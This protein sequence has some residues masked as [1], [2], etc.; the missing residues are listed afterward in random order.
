MTSTASDANDHGAHG[1]LHGNA[2]K[3]VFIV[4]I[5]FSLFQVWTATFTPLSTQVVRSVHVGFLLLTSFLLFG[6]NKSHGRSQI[7]WYDWV[8]GLT[9]FALGFYHWVFEADLIVR[10]GDPTITDLTVGVIAIA[11][12][13]EAA[14][15]IM[16]LALPLICGVF[17]PY[18]LLGPDLPGP[19]AHRGFGFDQL[20]DQLFLGTEGIYGTPTFVSATY[21]FLFILFGSFLEHA[22]MI[23]LFNDVSLGLVG[24]A[25]GGP[26]KVSVISSGFMGT[27]NGSGVANVLTTGQFTIPLMIKF[28]YRP[29]FAGAV[30][31]TS[32]MGGQIMPPVMGAVAFIM[33]ETIGVPYSEIALAAIIPAVLYYASVFWMVHLEAGRRGLLG[34]PK[35]EC[36]SALKAVRE[37]WYLFLPL[38]ALVTLLFSGYTPLFAGVI[39]LGCTA[40]LIVG[41]ALAGAIPAQLLRWVFWVGLGLSAAALNRAGFRA[42]I[43]IATLVL[44]LALPCLFFAKG[45][46]VLNTI[47]SSMADGARNAVGVGVACA[48][49][50]VLIGVTTLT[51]IASSFAGA[52]VALSGGNLFLA[53]VLTMIA[54]IVLG[55][56]LPTIPNYIITASIA[57]PALLQMG[58]PL[59]VSHMFVFYFGIMADLTPPVA[60]AA[61]AA[62]SIARAGHM[63]IGLLATRIAAAGYVVPFM[64]VYEPALM[65]QGDPSVLLVAYMVFKAL[66][67]IA[68]WGGAAIG[69]FFTDLTWTERAW[70]TLGAGLLVAALPITDELGFAAAATFMAWQWR[71]SRKAA[72]AA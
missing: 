55:T 37:G 69:H 38:I 28:G 7:P 18:A 22:G 64:A 50:G 67:G 45:R 59:I 29:A 48:L 25:K 26:A 47:L 58:V 54:C 60:L 27:I 14:R 39:G 11:L 36:P 30:E 53:L 19:L 56:G 21:I 3:A 68:L 2:A 61:L 13:F 5:A 62:S 23:R 4:G 63:Q 34:L 71:K 70:A 57:A 51:G 31:A 20:I 49:V 12:V 43:L 66:L 8:L 24:W 32:S 46:G 1:F 17:I 65:L 6:L 42:E 16:G 52:V 72:L 44:G 15:R 9:G 40:I 10:S 35:S 41:H 33:A